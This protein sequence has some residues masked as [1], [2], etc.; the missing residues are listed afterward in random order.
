MTFA[1]QLNCKVLQQSPE[2]GRHEE[3]KTIAKNLLKN[4]IPL[5][6]IK[7]STELSEKEL[8]LGVC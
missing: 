6:V 8:M 7:L 1:Q 3:T 4:K 5:S 2:E